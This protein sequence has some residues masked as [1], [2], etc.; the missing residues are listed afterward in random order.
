MSSNNT[1]TVE[2]NIDHDV[3]LQFLQQLQELQQLQFLQQLQELQGM[4]QI[5]KKEREEMAN[6]IERLSI[7]DA[8]FSFPL[9]DHIPMV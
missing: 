7:D 5:S 6:F 1:T 3:A 2:Y 8:F 4:E 9:L